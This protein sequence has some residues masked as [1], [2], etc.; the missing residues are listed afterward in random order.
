MKRI[1]FLILLAFI[2]SGQAVGKECAGEDEF[3]QNIAQ[4]VNENSLFGNDA[5]IEQLIQA[6]TISRNKVA[7]VENKLKTLT[8]NLN[9]LKVIEEQN[10]S[11]IHIHESKIAK[12]NTIISDIDKALNQKF[13]KVNQQTKQLNRLVTNNQSMIK[14]DLTSLKIEYKKSDEELI[15]EVNR[16]NQLL[17]DATSKLNNA[18][19]QLQAYADETDGNLEKISTDTS[20][21]V[22]R[23]DDYILY[24]VAAIGITA[25]LLLVSFFAS[26]LFT[27]NKEKSILD[28][29]NIF[30]Q[31]VESNILNADKKLAELL[32]LLSNNISS[33]KSSEEDHSLALKVADE[34][35][36]IEKNTSRMDAKTKGLKQLIASVKRIQDNFAANGYEILK[37]L[38]QPYDDRMKASVSFVPSDELE[39]DEQ[40]ITKII[41]PQVNFKGT[42]IQAAQIEVSVGE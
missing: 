21:S 4:K 33:Q 16:L 24:L 15:A 19:K 25:F 35:V 34:I 5:S 13:D 18:I 26:R 6:G 40:I 3:Y 10:S 22:L 14:S 23:L 27:V 1:S 30:K 39:T 20:N 12:L 7:C 38:N 28:T 36:R 42:M 31:D 17:G 11:N 29:L 37:M 8:E 41:K 32:E 9:D 2:G